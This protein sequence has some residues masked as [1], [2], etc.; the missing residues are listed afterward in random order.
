MGLFVHEE[1]ISADKRVEIVGTVNSWLSG[2]R[3]SQANCQKF[4]VFI[5]FLQK[6]SFNV[7]VFNCHTS[8][9]LATTSSAAACHPLS[10]K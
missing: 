5:K 3:N 2:I 10:Y 9:L 4:T 7:R 8:L 6:Q 1:I